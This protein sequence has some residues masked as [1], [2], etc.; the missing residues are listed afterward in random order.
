MD[1]KRMKSLKEDYKHFAFTL[2]AVSTF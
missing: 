2:L 1:K